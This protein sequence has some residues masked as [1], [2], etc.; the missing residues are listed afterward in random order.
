MPLTLSLKEK[1]DFFAGHVRIEVSNIVTCDKAV[2]HVHH[3]N[4]K[5]YTITKKRSIQ[6]LPNVF[7]YLVDS[8]Y[9]DKVNI[10]VEAPKYIS[11]LRGELYNKP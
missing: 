1:S 3:S 8:D 9:Q 5:R 11:I 7:V 4:N 10:V 2:L 6:I